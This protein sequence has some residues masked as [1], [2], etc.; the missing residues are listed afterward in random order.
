METLGSGSFGHISR[1]IS[2]FDHKEY[3]LRRWPRDK[4]K[5]DAE[6]AEINRTVNEIKVLR[7]LN[8]RH[9]VTFAGSYTDLK[10]ISCVVA[11]VAEM[12]LGQY[13]DRVQA[14]DYRTLQSFFGCLAIAVQY[15]HDK[16]IRHGDIRAGAILVHGG[17]VQLSSFG[18]AYDFTNAVDSTT[19][20]PQAYSLRTCA[21]ELVYLV[22]QMGDTKS[23]I[24]SLG[25][26]FLDMVVALKGKRLDDTNAYFQQHGSKDI[27]IHANIAALSDYLEELGKNG[28]A[29]GNPPLAWIPDMLSEDSDLRLDA[30][31]LVKRIAG[32]GMTYHNPFFGGCCLP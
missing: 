14:T 2:R 31:N 32:A 21:P 25:V 28:E 13:L 3:A 16:K 20:V 8:H 26:V 10:F 5:K 17:T 6:K 29:I 7:H 9:I 15:L 11:P 23:D 22:H 1:A 19:T 4:R 18:S 30:P 24:W 12:D 27:H